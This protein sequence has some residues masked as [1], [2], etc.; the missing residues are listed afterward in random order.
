[1]IRPARVGSGIEHLLIPVSSFQNIPQHLSKEDV[2]MSRHLP[3][4]RTLALFALI[5]LLAV[6][7]SRWQV[8]AVGQEK[9]AAIK[10]GQVH[11]AEQLSAAFRHAAEVAMPSVVTIHSKTKGHVAKH[12]KGNAHSNRNHGDDR[13]KD[14]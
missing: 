4:S 2:Y 6:G 7:A 1:M 9:P 11:Q 8:G 10:P 14:F 12:S 3:G 13:F 5:G